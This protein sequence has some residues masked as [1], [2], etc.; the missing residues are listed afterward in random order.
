MADYAAMPVCRLLP[1]IVGSGPW[2]MAADEVMLESAA[3]GTASLRFYRWTEP[4]LSLGYFQSQSVRFTDPN[5]AKLPFVRRSTG[6]GALVHDR[7]LTYALALPS[8][9]PWQKHAASW[10]VRMHGVLAVALARLGL[11]VQTVVSGDARKLGEVLCFLDQT[12]GDLLANGHKVA[13]S[14]QRRHKT[15]LL[16]HGGILLAQSEYSPSL[17]GL[18]EL[19]GFPESCWAGVENAVL[20][21]LAD[22]AGWRFAEG[23]WSAAEM[24]RLEDLIE[25]KYGSTSWNAKR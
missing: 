23:N 11:E 7:E 1:T 6:G 15:A 21:A 22:E 13:G 12:A 8:G 14:A 25:L 10:L 4:T 18:R 19:A 2:H 24:A 3:S 16:Q 9:L 20:T 5:L 17:P